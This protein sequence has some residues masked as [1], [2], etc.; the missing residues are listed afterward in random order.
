MWKPSERIK[1]I[2]TSGSWPTAEQAAQSQLFSPLTVGAMHLQQRTWI[3]AMVPW[4]AS[5]DGFVTEDVIQWYERFALGKP[6]AIVIEATGI[7]DVPSGP[8][9][10]IGHDR[11]LP[12]LQELV[13]R[14]GIASEGQT[15]LLIQ[16]IDFLAIRR[17][18]DP[19]KYFQRFM[20][21]TGDMIAKL[22]A[23]Q[24]SEQ[25][26]RDHVAALPMA[27]IQD[28]LSPREFESL[29]MGARERVTDTQH[30]HIR[31]LPQVLPELFADAA[32]RARRAGFDGVELHYAHAYTVAS[33][34]SATNTRDDGYG[35]SREQ[36]I[37]L[38]LEIYSAVRHSV[39]NDYPVGCRF[40]SNECIDGGSD[41]EDARFFGQ[42]LAQAGNGLSVTVSRWEI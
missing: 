37:R 26:I 15:R 10:R 19:A 32:C 5:D 30:Q 34:L 9:L 6:G 24:W 7:R 28:L 29:T 13:K 39:G 3:P 25:Q 20:P 42:Q 22:K 35:G 12:G 41:V 36:R 2:A 38:P 21:V 1:Y 18:P 11:F 17:R 14:V 27:E 8:L 16:L 33:F 31:E 40:L 23:Q 4:R